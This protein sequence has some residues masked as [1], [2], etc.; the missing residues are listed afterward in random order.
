MGQKVNPIGLRVGVIRSW[1]STWYEA[2]D[3]YSRF[4]L[5]DLKVQKFIEKEHKSAGIAKINIERLHDRV[6]VNIH[7]AR[8]GLLI[9]RKGAGIEVLKNDLQKIASKTVYI[10][11]V[12]VKKP[13]RFRRQ[14]AA[15]CWG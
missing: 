7:A 12:E 11:I 10:N 9:G 14:Y 1:D 15:G 13:E 3:K 6:N 5:E 4:V 2:K 8:P